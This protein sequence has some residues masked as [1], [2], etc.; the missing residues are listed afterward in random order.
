MRPL[1]E[2]KVPL[3]WRLAKDFEAAASSNS[4]IPTRCETFLKNL[5]VICDQSG[6]KTLVWTPGHGKLY[7]YGSTREPRIVG[8]DTKLAEPQLYLAADN[9]RTGTVL[10]SGCGSRHFKVDQEGRSREAALVRVEAPEAEPFARWDWRAKSDPASDLELPRESRRPEFR[11]GGTYFPIV[12]RPELILALDLSKGVVWTREVTSGS[13]EKPHPVSTREFVLARSEDGT[14]EVKVE[15]IRYE[16]RRTPG[17][18]AIRRG[19]YQQFYE[20]FQ[21]FVGGQSFRLVGDPL[22]IQPPKTLKAVSV[23]GGYRFAWSTFI[24]TGYGELETE[25]EYRVNIEQRTITFSRQERV[26]R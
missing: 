18:E 10:V 7:C 14:F 1:L 25:N 20:E 23:E 21:Y 17:L 2:H 4:P 16:P 5:S 9:D 24:S 22:L 3:G 26:N 15:C 6:L 19:S 13:P 8:L 12:V 11:P